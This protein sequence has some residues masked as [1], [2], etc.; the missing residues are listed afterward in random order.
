MGGNGPCRY[1]SSG[2]ECSRQR[3]WAVPR[4]RL[5][6]E[7]GRSKGKTGKYW[8]NIIKIKI[9]QPRDLLHKDSR[10]IKVLLLNTYKT[11]CDIYASWAIY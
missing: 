6:L 9:S 8:R 5:F 4:W 3:G 1:G 11:R 2:E 10:E 7:G